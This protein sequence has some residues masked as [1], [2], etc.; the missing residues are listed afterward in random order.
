[1][2]I[3]LGL[4]NA[5]PDLPNGRLLLDLGVRAEALGFSSLG[6]LGRIA[7]PNY[8]ELMTLAAAAGATERI[9]L[10][11]DVL[12]GPA[13]DVALLAKQAASLDQLS[14]GRLVLGVGVGGRED[15]F[16]VGGQD[17]HSR[18]RRWDEDLELLHRAWR[19]EPVRGSSRPISPRPVNGESVPLLIGGRAER[20]IQRLTRYGIGYTQGGGSPES[21]RQSIDKVNEVWRT[22]GRAGDPEFRALVY[23][24]LGDDA[25]EWG[26]RSVR[27][28]YGPYGERVWAGTIKDAETARLQVQAYA[29]AGC[30]ELVFFVT[31][32]A[33]AQAER[34]AEAVLQ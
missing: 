11:T 31:A 8:E 34:L 26:E 13:R 3:A 21:L 5:V 1:M 6:T 16:T 7:Y 27:D 28:Y 23:F 14:G 29:E 12:L 4:P 24:A 33:V 25:Q 15:D 18:G 17:F 9:G 22:A 32:P 10:F 2:K 19:G 20:A 30:D